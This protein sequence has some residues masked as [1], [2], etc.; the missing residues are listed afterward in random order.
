MVKNLDYATGSLD[1]NN[2][3]DEVFL[4][5]EASFL[6]DAVSWGSST[7]AFAP[8]VAQVS[9]GSSIERKP[10]Y[11]DTDSALDWIEQV[12]PDPGNV[13]YTLPNPF[14]SPSS[15]QD[16]TRTQTPQPT[17]TKTSIPTSTGTP[18]PT[19][20]QTSTS[21]ATS[22]NTPDESPGTPGLLISEVM[23]NPRSQEPDGEWVEI[24]NAGVTTADL[25][26]Y[27]LGDEE[28]DGG[29][30]GM[31]WFPSG[32]SLEPGQ[33]I[34]V[35]N[36][37]TEFKLIFNFF[38][39][40]EVYNSHLDVP[41]MIPCEE[42]SGG[43]FRLENTGDEVFIVGDDDV[44]IDV[45]AFGQ[46]EYLGFYPPVVLVAEGHSIERYPADVDTN[47]NNDWIDQVDPNPGTVSLSAFIR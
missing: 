14:P 40:Y 27:K 4:L 37:A 43:E 46:S 9:N 17:V 24:W 15:T 22:T 2:D 44:I 18:I 34:I 28:T 8:S 42:C 7:Y 29:V 38:P 20:T 23:Y 3:G 32:S 11:S 13:D 33:I 31:Y 25:S 5:D 21:T 30:E 1:L 36:R 16:P 47:T 19:L 35:A 39:D 10:V 12:F 6:I 45:V 26:I 41:D